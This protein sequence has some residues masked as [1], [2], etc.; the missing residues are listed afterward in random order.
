MLLEKEEITRGK[1]LRKVRQ[2]LREAEPGSI[3]AQRLLAQEERL[4]LGG[5]PEADDEPQAA[6]K[7]ATPEAE[8]RVPPGATPLV[9]KQGVLRGYRTPTGEYVGLAAVVAEVRS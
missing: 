3:A 9:D 1:L 6:S 8:R 5:K 2:N 7:P 4:V